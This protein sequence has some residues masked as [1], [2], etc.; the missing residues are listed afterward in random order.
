MILCVPFYRV[1]L[2]CLSICC[3]A[4]VPVW[5][6]SPKLE[7]AARTIRPKIT[8]HLPEFLTDFPELEPNLGARAM[9]S[10]PGVLH[11]TVPPFSVLG[12]VMISET[13][14]IVSL[15]MMFTLLLLLVSS[16]SCFVLTHS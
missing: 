12:A 13:S 16:L 5:E 11:P 10:A 8:S 15:V 1:D 14:R 2:L 7:Y 3:A 6:A 4:V 9:P